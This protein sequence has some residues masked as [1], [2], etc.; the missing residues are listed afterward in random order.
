MRTNP[1]HEFFVESRL[2]PPRPAWVSIGL[3]D[4]IL[5]PDGGGRFRPLLSGDSSTKER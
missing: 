2:T 5:Q 3:G 1:Q 4:F